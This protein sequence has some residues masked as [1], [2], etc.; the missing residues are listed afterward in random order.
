MDQNTLSFE[1]YS[2]EPEAGTCKG[3]SLL[4]IKPMKLLYHM[5]DQSLSLVEPHTPNNSILDVS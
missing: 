4:Q 5:N 2:F 3:R 1:C